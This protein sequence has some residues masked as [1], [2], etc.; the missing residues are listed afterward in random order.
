M[1]FTALPIKFDEVV[2]ISLHETG[3]DR[4]SLIVPAFS[5]RQ[6]VYIQQNK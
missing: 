2:C 5:F 3:R 6:A 1:Q 4:F